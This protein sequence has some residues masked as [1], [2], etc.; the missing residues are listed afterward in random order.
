[1]YEEGKIHENGNNAGFMRPLISAYSLPLHGMTAIPGKISGALM[2]VNS[3]EDA[4]PLIHGPIGCAFQRKINPFRPYFLFPDTPCTD[5]KDI[6]IVYGGEEKLSQGIKETYEKYHPNLIVV[7]TTCPS[8]LIGDDFNAV[9]EE[10]KAKGDVG[11]DV[12][13]TTGDFI[14]KSRPIGYQ[15]TLYAITDQMLCN[16]GN[17]IDIE[18]E[19]ER[20]DGSV[21]LITFALHGVGSKSK[22]AEMT[23]MLREMGIGINKVCFDH[24]TVN[25]LYDLSKAEL[26]ITNSA[27][28][29]TKLMKERFGVD[30]YELIA[31]DRYAKTRDPELLNPYGIEGSAR[32]FMEIAQRLDKEGEAEEVIARRKKDALERLSKVKTALEGKKVVGM[33]TALLRDT[34]MKTSVIISKTHALEKRLT[35]EAI[36]E[37]LDMSVELARKYGSDPEI[38]VNPTFEEEIRAIKKTGTDLV[39]SSGATAHR[40]NK[41]GIRTFNLMN[42]MLFHQ[43]IGFEAPIELAILLKQALKKPR[44]KNPLLSMLEYDSYRT[45]LIPEWATLADMFGTLREAAVGD[46]E[47]LG[48]RFEVIGEDDRGGRNKSKRI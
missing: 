14:G 15:D 28:V 16:N 10:T 5:M 17:G 22:V 48:D 40:Y 18:K 12:V 21:N 2:A 19:I 38:L 41:E 1:M 24:T 3:I 34:G 29:W 7:I 4:V 36:N 42:F 44:R 27:V 8:D 39:I 20:N 9:I 35:A 46:K 47:V 6:D 31:F 33:N 43:R 11:C 32:V 13:Y 45:N 25:D 37:R 23:S 30:H 26:T